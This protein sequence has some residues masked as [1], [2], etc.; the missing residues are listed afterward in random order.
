MTQISVVVPVFNEE[1]SL[2]ELTQWISRVMH[3][4]GFSYELIYINDGSSDDSWGIINSLSHKSSEVKGINFT[5]NY[6]KSAA[7]DAGFKKACGDVVI[8][9]DADLQDSP[10]EIP[11]LYVMITEGKF[12]VVSGWKKDRHDPLGKTIPSRFFNGVTRWISGIKLHDFNCGLKAYR[13]KVVK[14][15]HIYGEMHRYIPLLAKWNG[16]GK[17]GEKVVQHQARKYGYSKFGIERF[18]NG[19]LDLISVSFVHRYK[20]KP[21]H[22]F[23]F[24][25]SFSFFTGFI[26]TCWLIFEKVY[27]LSKGH[28]VR[29]ITDQPLFFLALVALI[30][31]VQLFVT[32][33]IAELMTSNQS[34]E[35]E[36]KI[37]EEINFDF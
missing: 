15:I 6:G 1:E 9:M 14:N 2:P 34:K 13:L 29:E 36:Y 16:F 21:M 33:F 35:A 17:I 24:L 22:F 3:D 28:K 31:G 11:S 10:D 37:D 8:T 4:H 20:K 18:L 30:I 32:G 7:L 19:F 27:G 23:G 25:G 26:I 12:D 5:R